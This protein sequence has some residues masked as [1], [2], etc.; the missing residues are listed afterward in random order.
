MAVGPLP[1]SASL[2][3]CQWSPGSLEERE[4]AEP[5]LPSSKEDGRRTCSTGCTAA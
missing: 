4:L 1:R 3:V 2:S 5:D